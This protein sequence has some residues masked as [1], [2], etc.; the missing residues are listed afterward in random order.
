[1]AKKLWGGRFTKST[2]K[3]VLDFT[4]SISFDKE[5]AIYDI[6]GS[7]AHARM[8]GKCRIIKPSEAATLV[9]G[10]QQVKNKLAKRKLK[11]SEDEE[12]IHTAITNL[13]TKEIGGVADKLHTARSRNDQVALDV[14]MYCKDKTKEIIAKIKDL[15]ICFLKG[16]TKFKKT[17]TM[18]SYTHLKRAQCILLSHQLLAY[19]EMLQR[20]KERLADAYKRVDVMPLGSVA[21]RGTTLAIDRLYVAKQLGFSRVSENSIDAVSDRDFLLEI[22]SN[23]AILSMHLSRIAEDFILWSTDEFGFA[24]GDDAHYTGSSMMPNKKNPDPL[25]LIRGYAGTIYGDLV[26]VLVLMKG[27][28]L[29]YNRDMQLDKPPLF[30]SAKIILQMLSIL[31]KVLYGIKINEDKIKEASHSESIFAADISEYLTG[32]GYPS[33]QAHRI[34]G[35]LILYSLK[36]K[37]PIKLMPDAELKKFA[38]ELNTVNIDK[39]LDPL[40]SVKRVKSYGGTNP[41]GVAKQINNWKKRLNARI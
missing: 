26:S 34:A 21:N 23:L 29:S 17:T 11:F 25:E 39:L 9:R 37:L 7:L 5:L 4:K 19:V 6:D 20:D 18:P 14:R 12:D 27:L 31:E 1:M 28:P 8:L 38:P 13:L 35:E 22:L 32:L 15:Q 16:A 30:E 10:L 33:R 3:E 2:D 41:A 36:N 40:Q 24:E